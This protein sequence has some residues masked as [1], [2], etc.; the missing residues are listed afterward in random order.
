MLAVGCTQDNPWF[1]V[2]SSDDGAPAESTSTTEPDATSAI[3]SGEPIDSSGAPVMT[4]GGIDLD[5]SGDPGT[6][7]S[8]AETTS[9]SAETSTSSSSAEDSSSD[10]S[11]SSDPGETSSG[12]STDGGDGTTDGLCVGACETPNCGACPVVPQVEFDGFTIDAYEVTN[13]QYAA[14]LAVEFGPGLQSAA[15]GWNSD[16]TPKV[17][18]PAQAGTHPVVWVDWCD[19]YEYCE[20]AGKRLCGKINGGE[21]GYDFNEGVADKNTNQWYRACS[22]TGGNLYPYG[23]QFNPS[24]CNGEATQYDAT[25]PVG[26]MDGCEGSAGGLFDMSGNVWELVDACD[27][28][29]PEA[30]CLRRGGGFLSNQT[31]LRCDLQSHR[32]RNARF[33]HVGLR[34]CTD[35]P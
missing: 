10:T 26:I 23:A 4:S 35:V 17:W 28:D 27:G 1:S 33:D 7:S 6:A 18:P 15:C 9:P 20:W 25:V 29:G 8:S 16:F 3:T 24:A 22:G 11:S 12:E 13:D 30:E 34:C 14:F 32:P 19:A 2:P 31:D 5:T 21:G